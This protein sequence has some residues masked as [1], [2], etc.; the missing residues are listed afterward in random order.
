MS[1]CL[2]K[3]NLKVFRYNEHSNISSLDPAFAKTLANTWVV[4][5]LFNS[6]VQLDDSLHI[7]PDVAKSWNISNE[8]KTYTFT[9]RND[10][11]FHRHILFGKDSTRAVVAQDFTYSFNRLKDPK[12]ASPGGWILQNVANYKAIGDSVFQINLKKAFPPFLGLLAMKYCSVVPKEAV[13]Y[14]GDKF[15][16][17]PIG[18]GPFKFKLWIENTKLVFLKNT[19]YHEVDSQGYKL[20]YLDAVA[21]TFLPDKQSE[22]YNLYRVI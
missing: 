11:Y 14:F 7:Q 3:S 13:D 10:V 22:F 18:T 15:R 20:P 17:H 16:E 2:Q 12:V 21:I 9:L 8:G 5:Q 6:L 4:N 19:E 1:Y